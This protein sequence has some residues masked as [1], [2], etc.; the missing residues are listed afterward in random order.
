MI[1][2]QALDIATEDVE[3]LLPGNDD[4]LRWFVPF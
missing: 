4:S 1:N 3:T 2:V